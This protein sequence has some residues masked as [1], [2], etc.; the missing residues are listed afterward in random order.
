MK[1]LIFVLILLFII[2]ITHRILLLLPFTGFKSEVKDT[3]VEPV[4]IVEK[5]QITGFKSAVK[6]TVVEPVL[7]VEKKQTGVLFERKVNGK[8][9]WHEYGNKDYHAKYEGE[10]ENGKPNG[11][12]KWNLPNG[13]KYE[14]EWKDGKEHGQ[15]TYTF[16][17]G[18]KYEGEWKDGNY[19]GQGT[20]TYP[21]G[22]KMVG[23]W[24][25]GKPWNVTGY[26]QN[27]N[28]KL[29]WVNGK[30]IKQ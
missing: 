28:K 17:G 29:K 24:R 5:K 11:Q 18:N 25:K 3:V 8:W 10:I 14:G 19:H 15:G 6:D 22:R 23:K 30:R 27:G 12:G 16:S 9:G 7:Q 13:N 20:F 2:D 4:V 21:D 1:K 26:D